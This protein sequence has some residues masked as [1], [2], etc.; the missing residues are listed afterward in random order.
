ML[1]KAA[2]QLT[3]CF[4]LLFS[5]F[6]EPEG[7]EYDNVYDNSLQ[8]EM[9]L[10]SAGC[11]KHSSCKKSDYVFAKLLALIANPCTEPW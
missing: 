10:L 6:N 9:T 4:C 5:I 2:L 1:H 8:P 7:K 11:N 3:S